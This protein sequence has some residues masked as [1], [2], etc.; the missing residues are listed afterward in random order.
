MKFVPR[1][2]TTS[3][4][5]RSWSCLFESLRAGDSMGLRTLSPDLTASATWCHSVSSLGG[6]LGGARRGVVG[7]G[8]ARCRGKVMERDV[9]MG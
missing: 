1:R 3:S 7:R 8:V 6:A 2:S 5:Q 4:L 9:V